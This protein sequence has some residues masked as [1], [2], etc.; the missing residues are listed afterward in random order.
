MGRLLWVLW[1]STCTYLI[2]LPMKTEFCNVK[3]WRLFMDTGVGYSFSVQ[4]FQMW[5]A[6]DIQ[7]VLFEMSALAWQFPRRTIFCLLFPFL[8]SEF[9]CWA[10]SVELV[11]PGCR[12][13]S[14]PI[15][16]WRGEVWYKHRQIKVNFMYWKPFVL[17]I[18]EDHLFLFP[19]YCA[20]SCVCAC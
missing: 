4:W 13:D 16:T 7:I 3:Q 9:G 19:S 17:H 10:G 2:E 15:C 11:Y 14:Q 12:G 5:S 1:E 6:A 20:P 8:L 18:N